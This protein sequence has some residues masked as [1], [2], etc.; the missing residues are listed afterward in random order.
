MPNVAVPNICEYTL[1]LANRGD[2]QQGMA[3]HK[4]V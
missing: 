4:K 2:A 3:K 1:G